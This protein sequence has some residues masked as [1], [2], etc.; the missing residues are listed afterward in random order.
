MSF[1]DKM[2][3]SF[4]IVS[5]NDNEVN[6]HPVVSHPHLSLWFISLQEGCCARALH[7]GHN[8]EMSCQVSLLSSQQFGSAIQ[9]LRHVL[10]SWLLNAVCVLERLSC[11]SCDYVRTTSITQPKGSQRRGWDAEEPRLLLQCN[12]QSQDWS[13]NV[14]LRV[15]ILSTMR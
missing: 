4:Q 3:L 9:R 7:P 15:Y 13:T 10:Q 12:E 11:Q 2:V 6:L 1:R 8:V 14:Y 5:S